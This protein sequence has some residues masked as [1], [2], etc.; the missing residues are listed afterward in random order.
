MADTWI[1]TS[2]RYFR[3]GVWERADHE[4][5]RLKKLHEDKTFRV[6]RVKSCLNPT[7]DYDRLSKAMERLMAAWVNNDYSAIDEVI[8]A[9][10][11]RKANG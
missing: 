9:E 2:H 7:G 10:I 6:L 5:E 8:R 11:E 3:H 4:C 1:V